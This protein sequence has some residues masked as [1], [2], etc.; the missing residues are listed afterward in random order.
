MSEE[1]QNQGEVV[2]L[3]EE[4]KTENE[5]IQISDDVVA[6]IAGVAV[7]EVPGVAGMA[8][9]FAG[10]I[11][12]V[13]SGKKNLAKG[14][15]VEVEGTKAKIDVN[16]IVEYGSRIPDVAFEIQNRVK[17]AVENMT[18]LNVEEVNVHVQGVN[19]DSAKGENKQEEVSESEVENEENKWKSEWISLAFLKVTSSEFLILSKIFPETVVKKKRYWYTY[20]T[21][22]LGGIEMK[23]L[24]KITLIIYSNIML[25]LSI[26]LSLLVF[27]W[28]DIGLVGDIVTKIVIG[29]TSGKIVLGLS[30]IFILLSIKCIFFDSTSREQI[31]ERQGVLLEN[32]SGKLM[33][34]KETIENLVNSVAL[35]FQSA[36]DVT[37]RVV[38]DKENN[39]QVFVNLI[40]NEEAIIKDLSANLQA[41]IK[42][43]VKTATD[44]EVKEVNIT[45]K[46]VAPTQQIE[47]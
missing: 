34:S 18:G 31:K 44:L 14:I 24:E 9:G 11:T 16:I 30:V 41:R 29:E 25:I 4:I 38:L 1:N 26:I 19:T 20:S 42:E 5:G 36:E 13:L 10:G 45:V 12:E 2:E 23:I 39:V 35:N 33:I 21:K 6:V 43:K 8:G 7:S 46:K 22:K 47:K 37:T 17:K 3:E 27:G 15:K 28:L 32:E 40:V